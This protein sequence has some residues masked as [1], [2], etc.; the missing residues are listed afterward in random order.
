MLEFR[1]SS[2]GKMLCDQLGRRAW[3]RLGGVSALAGAM[4]GLPGSAVRA[5][6]IRAARAKSVIVLF[7]LGGPP[8][9][10]TW[11][12]KPEAPEEV[13]G[14]FG[15]IATSL[16][17]YRVGELMPKTAKDQLEENKLVI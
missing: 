8:Q 13:R 2:A 3:L 17:G 7:H 9:H 15:T 5:G 14:S 6:P 4:G 10:E 12:P 1:D 11:D 16:P